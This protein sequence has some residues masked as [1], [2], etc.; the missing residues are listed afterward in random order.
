MQKTL[1][2]ETL[3]NSIKIKHPA[4]WPRQ[5]KKRGL[6]SQPKKPKAQSGS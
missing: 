1:N 6:K 3:A 2:D 4:K 5:N